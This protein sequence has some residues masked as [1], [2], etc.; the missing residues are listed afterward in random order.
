MSVLRS[1]N[2]MCE[3]SGEQPGKPQGLVTLAMV[4]QEV[5]RV[6][7]QELFSLFQAPKETRTRGSLLG[8]QPSALAG[9]RLENAAGVPRSV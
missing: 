8:G 3:F 5:D 2:S 7:Q 9:R 1:V 6:A 4:E